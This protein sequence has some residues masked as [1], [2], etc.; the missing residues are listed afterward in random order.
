MSTG[1]GEAAPQK[2][3]ALAGPGVNNPP[4]LF[5]SLETT[6]HFSVWRTAANSTGVR[7]PNALWGRCSL[8]ST[9]QPSRIILASAK[10]RKIFPVQTLVAQLVMEAFDIGLFPG[11]SG[12]DVKGF[13]LLI[14]PP[15]LDGFG[16]KLRTVVAAHRFGCTVA[17]DDS[18]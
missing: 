4:G 10:E 5:Q 13:D 16:D 17:F 15:V 3:P 8:Y 18:F 11:T 2:R 1:A 6:S 7:Y 9:R 12:L 14:L